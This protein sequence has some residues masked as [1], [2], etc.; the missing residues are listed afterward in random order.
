MDQNTFEFDPFL[1]SGCMRCMTACSTFCSGMTSLSESHIRIARH[2]GNVV[3]DQPSGEDDLIFDALIYEQCD[4]CGGDPQCVKFC[5]PGALTY[6]NKEPIQIP[7]GGRSARRTVGLTPRPALETLTRQAQAPS[8]PRGYSGNV[9]IIDLTEQKASIVPTER[10]LKDYDIDPRLWLGGEGF[11]TKILWEDIKAAIDP[12]GP[13]NEIIIAT[14]PW[15]ATA[16]PQSGRSMLGCINPETGG[17]SSGSFG[18][19]FPVTLKYAGFDIVIIRGKA[20]EPVYIF[21]DD[22]EISFH[23][24]SQLWG[25]E[26]NETVKV[27]RRR[28][29]ERYEGEIRVLTISVA[30]ENLVR[31]SPPCADGTSCPGRS[32]GGTVMGSKNLKAVAVRGTGSISLHN[33]GGLL[34]TSYNA[35]KTFFK[36]EPTI[37]LWQEQGATTSMATIQNWPVQGRF[38]ADNRQAA[39]MPHLKNVGCLNCHS[40]CY[41]WIQVKDGKY[42]E[43]RHLGGHMAFL[44]TGLSNIGLPDFDAWIYYERLMQRLGLDPASFSL[45]FSF[46]VDCFEKG[47]LGLSDTDGLTLRR[48]DSELAWEVARRIAH[49]EGNLGNLLADGVEEAARRIGKEAEEIAPHVKG[50]PYLLRDVKVQALIWSLGSLTSPRGGDWLRHHNVWELGFL[51]EARDTYPEFI[52]KTNLEMYDVAVEALDI[53]LPLKKQIFGVKPKVDAEWVKG[54]EGKALFSVW[55]ENFVSLFNSLIT[56]MFGAATQY[57]MVGFGP[58]TYADVLN[59]IT[60]W[61]ITYDELMTVG[62]RILNLQRVFNYRLKGWDYRNDRFADKRA[63]EPGKMGIYKGKEVPWEATLKEYYSIRGWSSDGI[64][65]RAKMRELGLADVTSGVNLPD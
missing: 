23:D 50:K 8:N 47:L 52:D 38:L 34:E 16:A 43:M 3:S 13:E 64:P 28:L 35:V 26:T 12:L 29:E 60:G 46:A 25:K 17:Y 36:E 2:E 33:A 59:K 54:T 45:A 4:L 21:I 14:G 22:L 44:S 65:T 42:G 32:G 18:W 10:F 48:G 39:D 49:R 9:A 6:S 15:T 27:V 40:P 56:C 63:Y 30:G 51:P 61:D 7:P 11:I 31:Y 19:L 57:L 62:E 53:P 41:H 58:T 55:T 37:K 20:A 1:C 5:G 24:A